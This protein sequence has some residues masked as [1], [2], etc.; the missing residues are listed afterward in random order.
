M[1]KLEAAKTGIRIGVILYSVFETN[2]EE[3]MVLKDFVITMGS[4]RF[5]PEGTLPWQGKRYPA[6]IHKYERKEMAMEANC[7]ACQYYTTVTCLCQGNLIRLDFGVP[8]A[9]QGL[10]YSLQVR[11]KANAQNLQRAATT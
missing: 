6:V 9:A 4:E 8:Q 3:I 11:R 2:L 1:L 7:P 10:G 5:K